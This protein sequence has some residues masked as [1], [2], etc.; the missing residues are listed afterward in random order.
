MASR[1]PK[2]VTCDIE[3]SGSNL[4]LHSILSWAFCVVPNEPMTP[5]EFKEHG[6]VHYSEL[7]PLKFGLV[8]VENGSQQI[9]NRTYVRGAMEVGSLGLECVKRN[10][11]KNPQWDPENKRLFRPELVLAALEKEGKNP[12]VAVRHMVN[13]LDSVSEGGKYYI[14]L[15]SDTS[16]F[17]PPWIKMY[18]DMFMPERD[19]L[20]HGGENLFSLWKGILRKKRAKKRMMG[21]PEER[22]IAHRSEDDAIQLALQTLNAKRQLK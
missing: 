3:A 6:L 13:W 11:K 14:I 17:D 1:L 15:C 12:W 20:G 21:V 16:L 7:K 5:K 9:V 10:K 22:D 4:S 19:V 8:G 18:C 2:W